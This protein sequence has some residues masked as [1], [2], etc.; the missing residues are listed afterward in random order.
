M[1]EPTLIA[2]ALF[3]VGVIYACAAEWAIHKRLMH[4]PILGIQHF[5]YGHAKVHHGVYQA[6]DTYVVGERPP[7]ELTLAWWAMP[8]PILLQLPLL[9]PFALFV[10]LPAAI[11]FTAALII[12]QTLY[13]TLHYYMHVPTD[14][15]VE[16][17]AWFKWLNEH[18]FQHHRKHGTNLNIVLPIFD[19]VFGTRVRPEPRVLVEA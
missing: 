5:Y 11:G 2:L 17:T 18:H 19:Y 14:R 10:S 7:R 9:V 12:Y 13:E 15:W 8:F 3:P 4:E 1:F 6:N 16:R